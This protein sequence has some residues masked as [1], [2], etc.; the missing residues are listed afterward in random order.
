MNDNDKY[1]ILDC[2]PTVNAVLLVELANVLNETDDMSYLV[3]RMS[4]SN[5]IAAV[6]SADIF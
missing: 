2:Q 4:E 6:A 5:F 1:D 3:R